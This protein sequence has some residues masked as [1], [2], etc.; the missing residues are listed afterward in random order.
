MDV[1]AH[2]LWGGALFY[3]QPRRKYFAAALIGMAPDLLSFGVFNITHPRWIAIR[4][5]GEIS[6]PPA[7]NILPQYVFYAYNLTHSLIVLF[8]AFSMLWLVLKKP[9]WLL[10]AWLLHILCDIPTHTD[11]YFPTP[12][13]WPLP[14]PF[15]N[16]ITWAT[17]WFM[18]ANYTA[19]LLT[20]CLL[21]FYF[22]GTLRRNTPKV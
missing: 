4:L 6:G 17:P 15:V 12:F 8:V 1:I 22:R 14:T 13:L 7:L 19:I 18:A 11:S 16:G 2:G 9:P 21:F 3:R 20:Y 10:G 5:A